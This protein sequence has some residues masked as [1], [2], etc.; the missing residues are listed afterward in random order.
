MEVNEQLIKKYD[1]LV[2]KIV[3]K[4]YSKKSISFK[5]EFEDLKQVAII[6]L[7][8]SA[9]KY[10]ED[11]SKFITFAYNYINYELLQFF[12]DDKFYSEKREK[13]MMFNYIFLE[14]NLDENLKKSYGKLVDNL[15]NEKDTYESIENSM[16]INKLIL[17]LNE[18]EKKIIYLRYYLEKSQNEI[19]E[20]M[21]VT[22]VTIS[23]K[24]KSSIMKM[25][26][27]FQ[28]SEEI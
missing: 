25:Q 13:R 2:N 23:R 26:K 14:D 27:E 3:H 9:K 21:N 7:I 20:L 17:I 8:K 28:K 5:Y 16:L 10:D 4:Y 19:A 12:R 15:K 22:Q 6:G 18:D 1:L 24:L 11:K